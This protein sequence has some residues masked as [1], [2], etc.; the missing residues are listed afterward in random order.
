LYIPIIKDTEI[1]DYETSKPSTPA[2]KHSQW[3]KDQRELAA[4]R[5]K[6]QLHW[7]NPANNDIA[8]RLLKDSIVSPLDDGNLAWD[9]SF[10]IN[11]STY[12]TADENDSYLHLQQLSE[13]VFSNVFEDEDELN[14]AF[15]VD[16]LDLQLNSSTVQP[17]KVYRLQNKLPV[18]STPIKKKPDKTTATKKSSRIANLQKKAKQLAK[19]ISPNS[20][21][22]LSKKKQQEM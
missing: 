14:K 5:L 12:E 17:N 15:D 22:N 6:N 16:K 13:S 19:K 1:I 4:D 3:I 21:K 8:D 20:S 10:D 11:I 9:T 2:K 7:L 18:C